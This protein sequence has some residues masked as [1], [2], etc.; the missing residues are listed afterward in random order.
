MPGQPQPSKTSALLVI[1][2]FFLASAIIATAL[3]RDRE[4]FANTQWVQNRPMPSN[5]SFAPQS[6][7]MLGVYYRAKNKSAQAVIMAMNTALGN[8]QDLGCSG[9]KQYMGAF[10]NQIYNVVKTDPMWTD[11]KCSDMAQNIR[12][13][14]DYTAKTAPPFIDLAEWNRLRDNVAAIWERVA[15]TACVNDKIDADR[16]VMLASDIVDSM[17]SK[18]RPPRPLRSRPMPNAM[19]N[20]PDPSYDTMQRVVFSEDNPVIRF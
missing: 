13:W 10:E 8:I 7:R 4:R 6:R 12:D 11:S 5:N 18:G 20:P 15:D 14:F 19:Y 3:W 9:F 2:L 16:A 1:A 17:C